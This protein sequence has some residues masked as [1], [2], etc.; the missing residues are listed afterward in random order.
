M[1]TPI[2]VSANYLAAGNDDLPSPKTTLAPDSAGNDAP[3]ALPRP[4]PSINDTGRIIFGAGC[5]L[6]IHK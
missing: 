6:P 5:R 3:S 4:L 1:T 2:F